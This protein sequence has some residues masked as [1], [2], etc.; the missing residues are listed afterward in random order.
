MPQELRPNHASDVSVERAVM[1]SATYSRDCITPVVTTAAKAASNFMGLPFDMA[2]EEYA[3]AVK[4]GLIE[5]S[6]LAS[7]KFG[8]T[9]CALERATLGP[10]ARQV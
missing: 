7:A 3:H 6:M 9:L 5:R 4:L 8:R 2:R 10:W 1:G